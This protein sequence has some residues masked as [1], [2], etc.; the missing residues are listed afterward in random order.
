MDVV[1]LFVNFREEAHKQQRNRL[2]C[3]FAKRFCKQLAPHWHMRFTYR[4]RVSG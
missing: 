2:E 1:V 4:I 3:T